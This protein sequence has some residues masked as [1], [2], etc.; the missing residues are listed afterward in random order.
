MQQRI[1]SFWFGCFNFK[2]RER[3]E[4]RFL[5]SRS[6]QFSSQEKPAKTNQYT[7]SGVLWGNS[8]SWGKEQFW[9][10]ELE[11]LNYVL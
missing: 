5:A 2:G 9:K 4:A 3:E 10:V 6:S 11:D 8:I 7:D 1:S